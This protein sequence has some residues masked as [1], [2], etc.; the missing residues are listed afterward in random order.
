MS[1]LDHREEARY[2]Q[3]VLL[4]YRAWLAYLE[5]QQIVLA[6]SSEAQGGADVFEGLSRTAEQ[7]EAARRRI[8]AL[9]ADKRELFDAIFE[10]DRQRIQRQLDAEAPVRGGTVKRADPDDVAR[11]ALTRLL[12]EARGLHRDDRRG[13]VP[14][15]KPDAVKWLA[16]DL[17]DIAQAPPSET[18]YQLAAGRKDARR[19]VI[20]NIIFALLALAAIPV[21]LFLLQ[22]AS[23][24]AGGRGLPAGNGATRTPW[25]V[26][27]IAA[28]DGSWAVPVKPVE[29]RWPAACADTEQPSACWIAGSFRPLQLCLPAERLA[30]LSTL[31]V[32]APA[33]LPSRVFS[34][35]ADT[36][37][38]DLLVTPCADEGTTTA[39]LAGRLQAVES[40]PELAPGAE[41]LA[42]FR[43][44]EITPRGRGEDPSI[45][46]GS[47]QLIVVVHDPDTNR[48]WGGLAPKLL[49]G[50]NTSISPGG[51]AQ[52]GEVRRFQ[53]L[54]PEQTE[55]FDV[56]WQVAVADQVVRYRA[57]LEPPPSRDA[58]LRARLRVEDVVITPSQ[59]T[60]AVRLTLHNAATTPLPV[61]ATDF[62]FQ[63]TA[64]RREIAVATLRPPLAPDERRT[65]TL[66]LPLESGVLQIGPFRYAFTVGR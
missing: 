14:R 60:M 1:T 48:D 5:A 31:R 22:P 2:R 27:R 41:A 44:T 28:G 58:V 3:D 33:G 61:E 43:V 7:A 50:D 34:L 65:I 38:G 46:A 16:L 66:D 6:A 19:S 4:S 51:R 42:G 26:Q 37:D 20:T 8:A 35:A 18:D 15:G 32:E 11:R 17:S 53:Y 64:T 10:T 9:P 63:T 21:L 47:M 13:M 30:G 57:T 56:R 25:P 36:T 55:P 12:E 23:R 40:P 49:L 52:D 54:I 24:S 59:Q 29:S 39:P 62:S 45:A